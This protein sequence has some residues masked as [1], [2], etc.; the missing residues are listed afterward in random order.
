LVR[1]VE[2]YRLSASFVVAL[3][4]RLPDESMTVAMRT[5]GRDKWHEHFGWGADRHL[6]ANVFDALQINTRATGNW[7]SKPPDMPMTP[8]PKVARPKVTSVAELHRLLFGAAQKDEKA[9]VLDG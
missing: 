6:M 8:R 3:I 4:Q 1:D 7:K 9:E 5:G 2:E